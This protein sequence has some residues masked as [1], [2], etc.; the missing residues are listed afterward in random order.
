MENLHKA[1]AHDKINNH[2]KLQTFL[3]STFFLLLFIFV[4]LFHDWKIK[5]E[6]QD[7][8]HAQYQI[9]YFRE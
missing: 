4:S 6:D 3:Q 2:G 1:D 9:P 5:N 7:L 8:I